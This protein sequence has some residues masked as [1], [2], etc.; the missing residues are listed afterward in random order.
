MGETMRNRDS[1]VELLRCAMMFLIVLGHMSAMGPY[2]GVKAVHAVFSLSYFATDAFV[3]ISGWYGLRFKWN[4]LLHIFGLGLFASILLSS[5]SY[6]VIGHWQW[7]YSLGWFGNAYVALLLISPFLNE[8]IE[9]LHKKGVL[10]NAW[11]IL[12]LASFLSWLPAGRSIQIA[13]PGWTGNSTL[14]LIFVYITG[15]V[16]SYSPWAE[17]LTMPK[18]LRIFALLLLI[19]IGWAYLAFLSHGHSLLAIVF[20]ETRCNNA[21]LTIALALSTFLMFKRM[22]IPM[23]LCKICSCV[24]PSLLSIYLL[25]IGAFPEVSKKLFF[26]FAFIRA[27]CLLGKFISFLLA[28]FF[29]FFVCLLIDFARRILLY[30]VKKWG[31]KG[32]L[33]QRREK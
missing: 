30:S 19:N 12:A 5:L 17:T 15:R 6:K 22:Q 21:P 29:V 13:P 11:L 31:K 8:G 18:A 10:N 7:N 16:V 33:W 3:F 28:G 32:G 9:T 26:D 25:H 4:K 24:S 2:S 14:A 27:D 1:N 20:V 23:W